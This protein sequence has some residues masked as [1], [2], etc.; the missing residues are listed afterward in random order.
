MKSIKFDLSLTNDKLYI[1]SSPTQDP[2]MID[3]SLLADAE[4][5]RN[6]L[7]LLKYGDFTIPLS[8]T[9]KI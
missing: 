8:F 2:L 6:V 9:L 5:D 7:A 3:E 1:S 4:V